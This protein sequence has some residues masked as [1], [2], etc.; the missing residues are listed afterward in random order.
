MKRTIRKYLREI[1]LP[2]LFAVVALCLF[3]IFN[4]YGISG[5]QGPF[6]TKQIIFALSGLL[7]MVGFSFFNYLYLKNYSLPVLIGYI[8][9]LG[10]LMMPFLFPAIRGVR[11]WI[12][13]GSLTIEPA[14]VVKLVLIVIMAKYFSQRHIHIGNFRHIIISGVYAA[15]PMGIVLIQPDLGSA[16]IILVIWLGM[17]LGAGITVRHLFLL[18]IGGIIVGVM[19]WMLVLKPYQKVRITSFLNPYNDPHGAGYNLIQSKVAIGSGY[20]FGNG[21]G[22]GSQASMGFLPESHNDFVFAATADQFGVVGVAAVVG[23]LFLLVS[24]VLRVG[25]FAMSNFGK[26]F[27]LGIGI[28]IFTHMVIGAGVNIGIMPVTGIPFPFLSYGGSNLISL[29][30]GLGVVQSIKRYG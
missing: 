24:R 12:V 3:S 17:L 9:S 28:L 8:L 5:N 6:F 22:K 30:I 29:M 11:S 13:I 23:V 21:W 20:W 26:L 1:D 18:L 16:I 4:I 7:V 2:L 15:I 19:G 27:C 14:E 10:F 25:R